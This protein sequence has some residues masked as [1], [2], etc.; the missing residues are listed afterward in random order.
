MVRVDKRVPGASASFDSARADVLKDW[1]DEQRKRG[2]S[3]ATAA[4][5]K[6]WTVVRE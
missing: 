4:L 1:K 5:R 6:K 2:L 3:D